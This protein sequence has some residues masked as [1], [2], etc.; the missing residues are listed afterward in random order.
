MF[1][2]GDEHWRGHGSRAAATIRRCSSA[3]EGPKVGA[4]GLDGARAAAYDRRNLGIS[5]GLVD[6][7]VPNR[8]YVVRLPD[9]TPSAVHVGH[10]GSYVCTY[11]R[12]ARSC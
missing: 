5:K 6:N 2:K 8:V 12:V 10:M 1:A 7:H 9:L 11:T 4:Y 3:A